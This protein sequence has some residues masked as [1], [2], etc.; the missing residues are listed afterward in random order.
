[1]ISLYAGANIFYHLRAV[2]GQAQ[3]LGARMALALLMVLLTLLGGRLV[4]SFTRDFLKEQGTP[5]QPASSSFVD[6]LSIMVVA[7]AAVSWTWQ[8]QTALTSWLLVGAGII[9]GARLSRWYGCLTLRDPLVLVLHWGYGW[10]VVALTLLGGATLG[11]GLREE[12]AVH[13]L[14]TG[15]I[16]VM[17][18]G[19][20]TRATLGHTG[21]ARHAGTATR[22]IYGLV[23]V[24]AMLRLFGSAA[25][26]AAIPLLTLAAVN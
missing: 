14:T 22:W 10:L 12:D 26:F 25:G 19:I 13:A 7:I 15:A 8:P 18:L 20:M 21:R 1:M 2:N 3:D 9:N 6:T 11:I 24:G 16:G 5:R 4:P 23:T 17:T